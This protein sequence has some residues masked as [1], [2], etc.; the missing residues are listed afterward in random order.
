MGDNDENEGKV[1]G[2]GYMYDIGQQYDDK[3]GHKGK[4]IAVAINLNDDDDDDFAQ[5]PK[6][7]LGVVGNRNMQNNKN[8]KSKQHKNGQVYGDYDLMKIGDKADFI[9]NGSGNGNGN[10]NDWPGK[11]ADISSDALLDSEYKQNWQI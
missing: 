7:K 10:V 9:G 11:H 2:N 5:R 6:V 8:A 3:H 1:I 4:D